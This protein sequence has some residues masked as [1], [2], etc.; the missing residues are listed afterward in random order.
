M[1]VTIDYKTMILKE[2]SNIP[3]EYF[4]SIFQILQSIQ[5]ISRKKIK[6]ESPTDRLLKLAGALENPGKLSAKEFKQKTVSEHLER[7]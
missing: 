3:E 4:P 6:K 5:N 7:K 2:I 1:A